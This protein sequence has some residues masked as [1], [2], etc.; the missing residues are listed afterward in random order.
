MKITV[1]YILITYRRAKDYFLENLNYF[2][3]LRSIVLS[4]T[5]SHEI[6]PKGIK[7]GGSRS[8]RRDIISNLLVIHESLLIYAQPAV[9]RVAQLAEQKWR[10][11]IRSRNPGWGG[12]EGGRNRSNRTLLRLLQS[13]PR[14]PRLLLT[15]LCTKDKEENQH[16]S[17]LRVVLFV[18]ID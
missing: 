6:S 17:F 1:D 8:T 11:C 18:R 5:S 2:S 15:S 9:S 10:N 7:G 4:I 3:F 14:F 12:K 16:D 13:A